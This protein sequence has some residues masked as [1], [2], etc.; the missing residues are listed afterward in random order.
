M[1]TDPD[2]V[3]PSPS[4]SVEPPTPPTPPLGWI[5]PELLTLFT[6]G[7]GHLYLA[8]GDG[9]TT[10]KLTWSPEDFATI[11]GLPAIPGVL[12]EIEDAHVFAHP[13]PSPDGTRIAL[14]GL[15][16]ADPDDEIDPRAFGSEGEEAPV[17][18][19]TSP[20][21]GIRGLVSPRIHEVGP[22]GDD[23][24]MVIPWMAVD[25][26][27]GE[28]GPVGESDEDSEGEMFWPGG[29]IYVAH[30]DGVRLWEAGDLEDGRLHHL[31]WSPDG[32]HLLVLH[33]DEEILH[34]DLFHAESDHAPVRL[35]DGMPLFWAWQPGGA[36]IALRVTEPE[37]ER[38][39]IELVEP[40]GGLPIHLTATAGAF[41]VPAW[42]PDGS[43][44]AAALHDGKE[45][46]VVLIDADGEIDRQLFAFPG[47][48]AFA[49]SGDG[50]TLAVA[51]APEG[52][53]PFA[54]IHL[55][56]L[57]EDVARTFEL[58]FTSFVW[59]PEGG[60]VLTLAAEEDGC[61]QWATLRLDGSLEHVG[62]PFVPTQECRVAMH[63]FE[64]V[65]SSH[66][67]L[68]ADGGHVVH[69]GRLRRDLVAEGGELPEPDDPRV[70]LTDLRTGVAVEI[71]RGRYACFGRSQPGHP[72]A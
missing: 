35:A 63:F 50:R 69:V 26:V 32:D 10:R 4:D 2:L 37:S 29:K 22:P 40:W 62:E 27:A 58:S 53:G 13:T 36:R 55:V 23:E 34:L 68:S 24:A 54:R 21:W 56:D 61:L 46:H 60:F 48:A 33:Q 42:R 17:D 3:S 72:P 57:E 9:S 45:D 28:G 30:I 67:F 18:E 66:P 43:V 39:Y 70:V 64:Q 12:G 6:G 7:D 1:P 8:E 52:A 5:P 15:L 59:R 20:P 47:R 16:P 19:V 38:S 11:H 41:Y 31:Q 71:G 65:T 44:F 49:W 25:D 51:V 14:F